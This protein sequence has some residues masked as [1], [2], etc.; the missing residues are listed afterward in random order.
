MLVQEATNVGSD[1]EPLK[2]PRRGF[3]LGEDRI[4][5][6]P[7]VVRIVMEVATEEV[8]QIGKTGP[9]SWCGQNFGN[10]VRM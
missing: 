9:C 1:P 10:A 7:L 8:A 6:L 5:V 3:E 2:R 4:V